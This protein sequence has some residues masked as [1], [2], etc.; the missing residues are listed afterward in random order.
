[1]KGTARNGTY[2]VR[3]FITEQPS[4]LHLTCVSLSSAASRSGAIVDVYYGVLFAGKAM[5]LKM[6]V[7]RI[8]IH[9]FYC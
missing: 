8:F 1:M 5:I 6:I 7:A 2:Q 4:A 3:L 9:T